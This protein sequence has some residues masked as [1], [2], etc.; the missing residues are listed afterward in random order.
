MSLFVKSS[1]MFKY[2]G[3]YR[4]YNEA[5]RFSAWRCGGFLAQK[6]NRI[7]AVEFCTNVS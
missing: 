7:T 1:I 2:F 4:F 6:L 3:S 5:Q